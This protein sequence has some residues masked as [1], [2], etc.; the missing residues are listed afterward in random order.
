MN[1][2]RK[3]LRRGIMLGSQLKAPKGKRLLQHV[4]V[5]NFEML[6]FSNEDVGRQIWLFGSYEPDETR[7]FNDIIKADDVCF[8]IGGN[9][10][11]F[12]L[13]MSKAAAAGSVHVFE[14]IPMNATLVK[15]NAELNGLS[16]VLVNNVAVGAEEGSANF[17]ISID[18]AYSSMRATGRIAEAQSIEVPLITLDNYIDRTGIRKVDIMKVDVEGAEDMVL[19]GASALLSDSARRP[20]VVLL[21]LFDEN[22]IPFGT[23]VGAIVERMIAFGYRANVLANGGGHLIAYQP[24]MANKLYNII[25]T[26][27]GSNRSNQ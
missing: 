24:S 14:P 3:M 11:Y 16:N 6:V 9:V 25:F 5:H 18:S 1:I 15:A 12:A 13:L 10:G 23:S 7:Y 8:D 27:D 19:V 21:E 4:S 20:R 26:I 22:L 2:F 17:S